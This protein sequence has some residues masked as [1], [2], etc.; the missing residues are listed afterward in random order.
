MP[1]KDETSAA[2][3][4]ALSS[5]KRSAQAKKDEEAQSE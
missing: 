2:K 1:E 3:Q 4:L 5:V